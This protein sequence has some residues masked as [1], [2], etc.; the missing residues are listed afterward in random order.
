MRLVEIERFRRGL[1]K[2]ARV[3]SG[4][5]PC[6][7]RYFCIRFGGLRR[8]GSGIVAPA[9][10]E[11]AEFSVQGMTRNGRSPFRHSLAATLCGDKLYDSA[12][13]SRELDEAFTISLAN[14]IESRSHSRRAISV[15]PTSRDARTRKRE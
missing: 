4:S 8:G 14:L 6:D 12:P 9:D 11:T 10:D 15:Q 5:S 3:R 1:G 7:E 13:L 2:G